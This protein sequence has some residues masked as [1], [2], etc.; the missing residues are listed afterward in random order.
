MNSADD[1][2]QQA[3]QPAPTAVKKKRQFGIWTLVTSVAVVGIAAFILG[4]RSES[5]LTWLS[6][7]QN[8]DAS[9]NLDFSS[10]QQVYDKLRGQFDGKL[11]IQKLIDGA[12]KG[13]VAATGDPYTVYFTNDE[14]KQ[15][16]DTLDGKFSGIGAELD[17]KDNNLVIV[18]TLDDSPAR[19]AG[20]LAGDLIAKV[21]GEVTSDW[22]I[23]KAVS[24]I[25]GEKG[26]TVK[27]TIVRKQEVKEFSIVR[28]EIV[29]PSVKYEI[30]ADNIGYL[31]ISRFA[32]DTTSLAKKAADEFKKKGVKGVVMD[33]RGNGGGYLTAAQGIASLWLK[34]KQIV[35]EER[36]GDKVTEQLYSEGEAPLAGIPTVVLI[37]G[38][39]ASASEIVAGALHDHKAAQ[40][41][42]VKSFGKGSVQ[43]IVDIDSGG[44][45]KVTIAKWF[46]PNGVNISKE[47]IQPDVKVDL[48]AEDI[49]VGR[50]LQKDKAFEL[51]KK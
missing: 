36:R 3:G 47:G 37:D 29:N 22:S 5:L 24:Q 31:R 39:S 38:G 10:V 28:A 51:L 1:N 6:D 32:D 46:T 8:K 15:F 26:T 48:T 21:N 19:K 4:T 23:D 43:Q 20:L 30:T 41:V 34:D 40:L 42:G 16:L 35:V 45:L 44:E 50:D 17:K 2:T 14:A 18:S 12:K 27:L 25:R 11:D 33:V 13:M 7:S 49:T 9:A